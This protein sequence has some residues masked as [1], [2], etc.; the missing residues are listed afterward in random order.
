MIG[1]VQDTQMRRAVPSCHWPYVVWNSHAAGRLHMS[2]CHSSCS[3]WAATIFL[4]C[5]S[6]LQSWWFLL[7][8]QIIDETAAFPCKR[9]KVWPTW[10]E[11]ALTLFMKHIVQSRIDLVAKER[12][13][14]TSPRC[15]HKENK[16]PPAVIAS[17]HFF[18]WN[19]VLIFLGTQV[20]S[21][22]MTTSHITVILKS[23]NN[24]V[25]M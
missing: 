8:R 20:P 11:T 2:A 24:D 13:P 19:L 9:D 17:V 22:I 14:S 12:S 4:G 23:S 7:M 5:Y 6:N 16:I 10:R 21:E 1:M 15:Q 25:T 3:Q 18:C